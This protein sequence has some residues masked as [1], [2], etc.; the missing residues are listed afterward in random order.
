MAA[1]VDIL[2]FGIFFRGAGTVHLVAEVAV[3]VAVILVG[4][5]KVILGHLQDDS[6]Q[7]E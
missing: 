5:D 7:C 3:A 4:V 1:G 2:G 6:N